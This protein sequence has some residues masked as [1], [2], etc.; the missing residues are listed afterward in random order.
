MSGGL[1]RGKTTTRILKSHVV[2]CHSRKEHARTRPE[3]EVQYHETK[4]ESLRKRDQKMGEARLNQRPRVHLGM[5]K[6]HPG[7]GGE[8]VEG[9][10][11]K[12]A[13]K[14]IGCQEGGG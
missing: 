13:T 6:G 14:R 8:K 10:R 7:K 11:A 1:P 12:M 2:Q 5:S 9:G 4:Q 3:I